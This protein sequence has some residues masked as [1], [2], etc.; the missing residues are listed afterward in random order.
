MGYSRFDH[1]TQRRVAWNAGKNVGTKRPL[2][3]KQIWAIRFHLDREGRLRDRALFDLAID[4]KLRGCDLVKIKIGD[5]VAGCDIR[6]RATVI[7]QKTNRPVQFELTA[8]VRAT[9]LAW[10]ERR[11]GSTGDYL[12]PSRVDHAGH[13]STRQ[14]AR[15]V[16]EWVTAIGL[17]KSEYGTHSL[18]RTK[19]AMIYRATGNIRAIQILLGHTKIENTVRYLGVDVEDALLLA[20]RTEI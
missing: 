12:F 18:R 10:L 1:A 6:N 11:G 3:Q 7:Q 13:M 19:A 5:V 15:L 16:D 4:S 14:Y 9:L 20:E 17:R 8:D 2:T